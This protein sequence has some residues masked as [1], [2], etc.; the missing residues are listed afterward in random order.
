MDKIPCSRWDCILRVASRTSLNSTSARV[1]WSH[2]L[3]VVQNNLTVSD[4]HDLLVRNKRHHYM[5][6]GRGSGCLS[7]TKKLIQD[8]S[9][10]GWLDQ[11]AEDSFTEYLADVRRD[12]SGDFYIP[13]DSGTF[14]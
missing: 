7:W 4:F 12:V 11:G 6:D 8:F 3:P 13:E 14:I 10:I 5:Y 1:V 2:Y 9:E